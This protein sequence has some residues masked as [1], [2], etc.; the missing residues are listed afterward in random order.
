M[1]KEEQQR[2]NTEEINK[3]ANF[4]RLVDLVIYLTSEKDV[5]AKFNAIKLERKSGV[6][7]VEQAI[8]LVFKFC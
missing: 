5:D 6:I 3:S 2:I 4:L 1:K 8:E 7:D